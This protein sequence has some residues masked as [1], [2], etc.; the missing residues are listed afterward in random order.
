MASAYYCCAVAYEVRRALLGPFASFSVA[1][2]ELPRA[3]ALAREQYNVL[4][5]CTFDVLYIPKCVPAFRLHD[6]P[7]VWEERWPTWT[8]YRD[9]G[10]WTGE[11][12]STLDAVR[13]SA[14]L[15]DKP[16]LYAGS[17]SDERRAVA[18]STWIDGVVVPE[19]A[20]N[21]PRVRISASQVVRCIGK[22]AVAVK[23]AEVDLGLEG[24]S[25]WLANA[26]EWY[27]LCKAQAACVSK[28]AV[29]R[30]KTG[31]KTGRYK[32]PAK[33][34]VAERLAVLE[35]AR[36]RLVADRDYD[37][38]SGVVDGALAATKTAV[39]QIHVAR[40]YA[41]ETSNERTAKTW[42]LAIAAVHPAALA[43]ADTWADKVRAQPLVDAIDATLI[44]IDRELD[45][46]ASVREYGFAPG[47]LAWL[48]PSQSDERDGFTSKRKVR[49]DGVQVD[50][51]PSSYNPAGEPEHRRLVRWLDPKD[52][53]GEWEAAGLCPTVDRLEKLA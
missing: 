47:E 43:C 5:A 50:R 18:S 35:R 16:P 12:C 25:L 30:Y 19:P 52:A 34:S 22:Y 11:A 21:E 23:D 51:E 28:P 4:S 1:Q 10:R 38:C 31:D 48:L 24:A 26:A 53:R 42:R 15:A 14:W 17:S 7:R 2:A 32:W 33:M 44:D 9:G 29:A 39:D 27:R 6:I 46:F 41:F 37:E 3:E 13:R 49:I 20:P 40:P 36:E 45:L 8:V